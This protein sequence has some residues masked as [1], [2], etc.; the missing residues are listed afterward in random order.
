MS[1]QDGAC[2]SVANSCCTNV[3]KWSKKKAA[4]KERPR[5][6]S[7]NQRDNYSTTTVSSLTT[8]LAGL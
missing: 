3:T 4:L 5:T 1:L 6:E 2:L 7:E 8:V